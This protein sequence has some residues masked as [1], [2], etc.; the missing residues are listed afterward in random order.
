[1]NYFQFIVRVAHWG[2]T[3]AALI[4]AAGA[5]IGFHDM[6]GSWPIALLGGIGIASIL[7]LGWYILISMGSRVRRTSAKALTITLGV[8]LVVAALGTS[9]WA[10]ATAIGGFGA[11]VGGAYQV[12]PQGFGPSR[13]PIGIAGG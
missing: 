3:V 8:F 7:A 9:G 5:T 10:L 11:G 13:L 6:T 12:D 2:A 1:M 4:V